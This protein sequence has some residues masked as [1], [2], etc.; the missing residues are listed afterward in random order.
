MARLDGI[1]CL[2][3]SR[4]W[5]RTFEPSILY[6]CSFSLTSSVIL[7]LRLYALY[8]GSK[9]IL[10]LMVIA[11]L[12]V[13]ATSATIMGTVLRNIVSEFTTPNDHVV[14]KLT[15][16][17]FPPLLWISNMILFTVNT[18][19]I[20]SFPFCFAVNPSRHFYA[21]W[22]P[23]LAFETLLCT[24]ALTRGYKS[25]RDQEIRLRRKGAAPGQ[26]VQII[27][28]LLRDSIFYFVVC[29]FNLW[30]LERHWQSLKYVCYISD[31]NAHLDSWSCMSLAVFNCSTGS[32]HL[33]LLFSTLAC[34]DWNSYWFFCRY[35][36]CHFQP[37][38]A[39][40]PRRRHEDDDR[41][42]WWL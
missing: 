40:P 32:A 25:Y 3:P 2:R 29:V 17:S 20:P 21:F 28:I 26:S 9:K 18:H 34:L 4:K 15:S 19:V 41:R 13:M 37:P 22:I 35:V 1:G 39:Q 23:I 30:F 6:S 24:L 12:S 7:Q 33:L 42:A 10:A 5:A 16:W 14:L 36:L 27:E 38:I 11:F 8:Y 31:D